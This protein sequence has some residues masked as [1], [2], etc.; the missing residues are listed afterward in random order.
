MNL[1][2]DIGIISTIALFTFLTR[3]FPF[4][5]FGRHQQP[6]AVVRYL[7][8]VLPSSVIAILVVYCLKNVQFAAVST[9]VPEFIAVF[10]VAGLHLWKR[11]NLLSI[12]VGTA[13]YMLMIQ[14]VF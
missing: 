2:R 4:A 9:F 14:F 7:G 12:G 10:I 5:L 11:N 8:K 6:P 3:V 13:S 1:I